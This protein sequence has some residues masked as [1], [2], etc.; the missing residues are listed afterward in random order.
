MLGVKSVHNNSVRKQKMRGKYEF[1]SFKGKHVMGIPLSAYFGST[2]C[3]WAS[4]WLLIGA[5]ALLRSPFPL[6]HSSGLPQFF[7]QQKHMWPHTEILEG[8]SSLLVSEADCPYR[9]VT[10][11]FFLFLTLMYIVKKLISKPKASN[12][13]EHTK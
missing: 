8:F 7:W 6:L 13:Y 12:L 10:L 11:F 3:F 4:L 9:H 1:S 5:L 2:V